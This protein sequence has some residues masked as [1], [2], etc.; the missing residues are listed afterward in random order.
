[1]GLTLFFVIFQLK[2]AATSKRRFP[3]AN[4][5]NKRSTVDRLRRVSITNRQC[6]LVFKQ[7]IELK[8]FSRAISCDKKVEKEIEIQREAA[9]LTDRAG[10]GRSSR[11][12]QF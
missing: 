12:I 9:Q 7:V 6:Q 4:P 11:G 5:I 1:M 2:L 3:E 8:L 10:Q